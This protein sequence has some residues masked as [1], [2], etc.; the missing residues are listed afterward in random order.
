[1]MV[2][3]KQRDREGVSSGAKSKKKRGFEFFV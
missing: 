3:R 2:R 1:M